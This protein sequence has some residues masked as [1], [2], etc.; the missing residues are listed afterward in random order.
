MGPERKF[1]RSR[2]QHSPLCYRRAGLPDILQ[3][4][5]VL[6]TLHP[7]DF[8]W[9]NIAHGKGNRLWMKQADA[10]ILYFF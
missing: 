8:A 9:L 2:D 6:R 7:H 3:Q 1:I 5:G 10:G 4:H